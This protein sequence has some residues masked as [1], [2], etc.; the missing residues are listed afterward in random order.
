[1]PSQNEVSLL[2][3]QI[4]HEVNTTAEV[5]GT[6]LFAG[7]AQT[8]EPDIAHVNQAQLQAAYRQK[9]LSQDR[10][11]LQAE[12]QRDP[13]QFMKVAQA[14]GVVLPGQFPQHVAPPSPEQQAQLAAP[15][16]QPAL[17]PPM[18]PVQM[19]AMLQA[20][21][22]AQQPV[23]PPALAPQPMPMAPGPMPGAVG[24]APAPVMPPP[25]VV[26]PPTMLP[27]QV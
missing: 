22:V 17:P 19:Q 7:N 18:D 27:P 13:Q 10:E 8:R 9:F 23:P 21:Q 5:L 3:D 4:T 14:I 6:Q 24:A 1:M 15:P 11:W 20:A 26:P 12:A 25:N 2:R 16:P